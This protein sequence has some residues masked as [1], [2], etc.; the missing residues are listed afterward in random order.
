VGY[1]PNETV[2]Q[3]IEGLHAVNNK[4]DP[5]LFVIIKAEDPSSVV[6]YDILQALN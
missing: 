6:A 4:I 1:Q 5:L 3:H 2:K